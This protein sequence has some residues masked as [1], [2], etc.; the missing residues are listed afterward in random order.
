MRH[1]QFE[2]G[3]WI[4]DR[5]AS[6]LGDGDDDE[7]PER[8]QQRC[9]EALPLSQIRERQG[10]GR[11]RQREQGQHQRRLDERREGKLAA[12]AHAAEVAGRVQGGQCQGEPGQR[13]QSDDDD[14][15]AERLERRMDEDHRDQRSRREVGADVHV[16]GD[17]K[18]PRGV[19][20]DDALTAQQLEDV[21]ARLKQTRSS[22]ILAGRLDRLDDTL[23]QR[24][25]Q[26]HQHHLS[27][28]N[29]D[30]HG[31]P[32]GLANRSAT[33][34]VTNMYAR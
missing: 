30:V 1:R 31:A 22:S 10:A 32:P 33:T 16:G 6:R 4:V 2:M 34:S 11:D 29:R 9:S 3:V 20:G 28:K 7:C 26:H 8:Q 5:D 23:E 13:E 21:V 14:G 24:R 19:L 17:V 27:H 12:H 15:V 18:D 25:K